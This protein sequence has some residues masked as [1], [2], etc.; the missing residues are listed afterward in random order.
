[1]KVTIIGGSGFIGTCL[2][3]IL[4][5]KKI[6]FE[7]LDIV[8]SNDFAKR[9]KFADV[10]KIQ[11]LRSSICG[12]IVVNLAAIHKDDANR[13]DY[14]ETNVSGAQNVVDACSELSVKKII[15]TS[16]VAVYGL[17]KTNTSEL[18]DINPFND[19]GRTKHLAELILKKWARAKG[20]SLF[21]IR[22]T[23]VFGE[24][25]RGNVFNLFSA[26]ANGRFIMIGNGENKKSMSYVENISTFIV[27][28]LP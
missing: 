13:K 23:V 25:N 17:A 21:V 22:P 15:F 10:R 6:D 3:K 4:S 8:Q 7:I 28:L 18:G 5:A 20:N 19:Y 14:E 1:M 12:D 11:T 2:C 9:Y 16:T 26:I 27:S 24:G